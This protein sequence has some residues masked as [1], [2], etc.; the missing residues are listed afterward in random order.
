MEHTD[1]LNRTL[2]TRPNDENTALTNTVA[3]LVT[4]VNDLEATTK[5]LKEMV[6]MLA[7]NNESKHKKIISLE[8]KLVKT[9]EELTYQKIEANQL[10][11]YGRREHIEL[12]GIKE[13]I[14]QKDIEQ[15]VID[16]LSEIRVEVT[17]KDI[18]AVHR[19]GK[20]R[21]GKNRNVIVKFVN[22]KDARLAYRSRYKLK[23]MKVQKFKNIFM[24]E[25]L[26]PEH[27]VI[28][29]RL[30]KLFKQ[31]I[32]YDVWTLNGHVFACFDQE[33]EVE[34]QLESDIDYY[35]N[36]NKNLFSTTDHSSD[37]DDIEEEADSNVPTIPGSPTHQRLSAF[38]ANVSR[39]SDSD[40]PEPVTNPENVVNPPEPDPE[41]VPTHEI[42]VE[43]SKPEPV[44]ITENV[45]EPARNINRH[46]LMDPIQDLVN[47]NLIENPL[48]WCRDPDHV[49]IGRVSEFLPGIPGTWG[50][51][52]KDVSTP[53]KREHAVNQYREYIL[54]PNNA[55]LLSQLESLRGKKLGCYCCPDRCHGE[56]L[57]ELLNMRRPL[58]PP[59]QLSENSELESIQDSDI[60]VHS[61]M[62]D[63]A[64][65]D[66]LM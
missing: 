63:L 62:S 34:V 27:R 9:N 38:L 48:E 41:P 16:L 1:R 11:Q 56:I 43:P 51:P 3:L 21:R 5:T 35:L 32:I 14:S 57:I 52:H 58:T 2:P 46:R 12:V 65:G 55:H 23:K 29:N 49:Y 42:I 61:I 45:D 18:V 33:E 25:N 37:E 60:S 50:N 36:R 39:I 59:P 19:L 22:R 54:D 4:K 31:N 17:K 10:N 30:Y 20:V 40:I 64:L 26:C 6:N 13:A 24:I 66:M 53:E 8:K 44:S 7:L 47:L 15:F 28:F